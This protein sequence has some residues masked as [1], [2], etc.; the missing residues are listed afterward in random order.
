MN[1]LNSLSNKSG[2]KQLPQRLSSTS[3]FGDPCVMLHFGRNLS[4]PSCGTL[5]AKL[6]K[7]SGYERE[8]CRFKS[9]QARHF[10]PI[11]QRRFR[12]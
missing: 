6:D 10:P 4:Y 3:G 7:A 11:K 1:T 12:F 9:Y 5:V 2:A 8:G